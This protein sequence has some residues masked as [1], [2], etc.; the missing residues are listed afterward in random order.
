MLLFANH[1]AEMIFTKFEL[2]FNYIFHESFDVSNHLMLELACDLSDEDPE[3]QN[4]K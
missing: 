4:T 3:R 2:Y 1:F